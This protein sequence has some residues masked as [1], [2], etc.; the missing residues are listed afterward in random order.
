[1][2]SFC[3]FI[4][5][6]NKHTTHKY[7]SEKCRNK[8]QVIL[9]TSTNRFV[10]LTFFWHVKFDTLQHLYVAWRKISKGHITHLK[11]FNINTRL[12]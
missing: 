6:D 10:P 4:F 8:M 9:F 12:D 3:F 11:L 7:I 5:Y 1:M 2:F